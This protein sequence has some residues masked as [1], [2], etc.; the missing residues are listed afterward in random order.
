MAGDIAG[1]RARTEAELAAAWQAVAGDDAT[2]ADAD[3]R[4]YSVVFAG[5][6]WGGPGPD[7]QG[8]VLARP[9]GTLVRGD[10]EIHRRASG[11]A[12]HGHDADP[13]YAS[14]VLHVVQSN[15]ALTVDC[16]GRVVPTV[17]LDD[18]VGG[19][20]FRAGH[21]A[22]P[23]EPAVPALLR[24]VEAAGRERFREKV[25]RFERDLQRTP[26]D[27]VVWRGISEALGYSPNVKP[28]AHLADV[29]SWARCADVARRHGPV[30][31][32]ALLLGSAGFL[33]AASLAEA[34][35]WRALEWQ[36]DVRQELTTADWH[37]A[38][39]RAANHPA[40]R[41][42]G[43]VDLAERWLRCQ[44]TASPT[45]QLLS[46]VR[47]AASDRRPRLW[48]LVEATPWIGRGR[49]QVIAGNVLLP[50]A[51]AAGCGEAWAL[52]ERAP[53][54]PTNHIV[55]YMGEQLAL[56]SAAIKRAC[57]Q[58]GLLHL[59]KRTCAARRCDECAARARR[60][61]P[62]RPGQLV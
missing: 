7:F 16:H 43:L 54:E 56:P 52:Y 32:T 61:E 2:L 29:V 9:D 18:N 20:L 45:E 3:G 36:G 8:A 42:R 19:G 55:R 14:V 41:L 31:L 62:A 12:L 57:Q 40:R 48:R 58:Q 28:F 15:D 60:S 39:V 46:A 35:V 25:A 23:C 51:A 33:D 6:R 10:V 27:Q 50:F 59:F 22:S 21:R 4:A 44:P 5:R 53:R 38:S 37:L 17:S 24:V 1:S 47:G 30:G 34:H 13:A 11:W 26:A 49:A